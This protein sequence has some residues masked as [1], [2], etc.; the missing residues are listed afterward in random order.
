MRPH[1]YFP[2]RKCTKP[3]E[4]FPFCGE[5]TEEDLDVLPD[6]EWPRKAYCTRCRSGFDIASPT[7]IPKAASSTSVVK[8]NDV[9]VVVQTTVIVRT[10]ESPEGNA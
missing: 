6:L 7:P 9:L 3:C 10:P 4:S 2:C 8:T 1:K 5:L